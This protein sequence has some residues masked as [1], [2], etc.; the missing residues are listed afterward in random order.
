MG[1]GW[2]WG[3]CMNGGGGGGG[4][5]GKEEEEEQSA[6]HCCS[7]QMPNFGGKRKITQFQIKTFYI[8]VRGWH[9]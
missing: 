7:Q 3:I 2:G 5:R 6:M 8:D 4:K 1:L 9:S